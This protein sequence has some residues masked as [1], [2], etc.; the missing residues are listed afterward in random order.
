MSQVGWG[1]TKYSGADY[2]GDEVA[3]LSD[4]FVLE[5]LRLTAPYVK[6]IDADKIKV[7]LKEAF[8][9]Q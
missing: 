8:I 2:D 1:I 6:K 5:I 7:I 3:L 4:P 9:M